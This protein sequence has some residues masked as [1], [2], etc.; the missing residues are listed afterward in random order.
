MNNL[1]TTKEN[2]NLNK[3]EILGIPGNF[4]IYTL[5]GIVITITGVI[6]GFLI[7]KDLGFSI[8]IVGLLLILFNFYLRSSLKSQKT[9]NQIPTKSLV[10]F[11]GGVLL[12]N[13]I[14][15]QLYYAIFLS[16][17]SIAIM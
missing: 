9:V 14:I 17:F 2:I 12:I 13:Y 5:I 7:S 8:G 6:L 4:S 11:F 1:K 3:R 15:Y 16:A 10:L